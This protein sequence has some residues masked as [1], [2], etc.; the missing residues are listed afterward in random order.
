MKSKLT[1]N[2]KTPE[3]LTIKAMMIILLIL[4]LIILLCLWIYHSKYK[5]PAPASITTP[6]P[7]LELPPRPDFTKLPTKTFQ[8]GK[9]TAGIDIPPGRYIVTT[10]ELD[11]G[12]IVVYNIVTN[13]VEISE[14]LGVVP[15]VVEYDDET[16]LPL[17]PSPGIER[18]K[19]APSV[20]IT[21]VEGQKFEIIRLKGVSLTFTP[22]D[23]NLSSVLTPGI[24]EVDYD[25]EPGTYVATCEEPTVGS[26]T[27]IDGDTPVAYEQFSLERTS[28][29]IVFKAGNKIRI[30]HLPSVQFNSIANN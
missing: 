24:W 4:I 5:D 1:T 10:G 27:V 20:T 18:K 8:I 9:Y 2:N 17:P 29:K 6:E 11:F 3:K 30:T 16:G 15:I 13:D 7:T 26:I 14:E 21:L 23:T 22:V 28:V 12:A 19:A 25:I